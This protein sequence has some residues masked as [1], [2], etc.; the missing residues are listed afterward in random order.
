MPSARG[1][2]IKHTSSLIH[3][4]YIRS[5]RDTNYEPLRHE[6]HDD[7]MLL[8]MVGRTERWA[9]QVGQSRVR[10]DIVAVQKSVHLTF[11]GQR[12][13]LGQLQAGSYRDTMC[14]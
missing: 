6:S 11:K 13:R 1:S 9:G 12:N 14:A 2:K 3:L 4:H 5:H 7:Q 8:M 10:Q